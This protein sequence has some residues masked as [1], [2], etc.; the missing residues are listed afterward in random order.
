MTIN[1]H[2]QLID[3]TKPRVMGILNVTPDSFYDGGKYKSDLDFLNQTEK[4]LDD[5]ATFIDIGAYSSRPG[6]AVVE[7]EDELNRIVPIIDLIMHNFPKAK[8][9]VDTFRAIVARQCVEHGA[10]IINDISAGLMD[11]LMLTTVGE[12]HVPYIMMHMRGT[13]L[14]MNSF[15]EYTDITKDLIFYFSE[16]INAAREHGISD[17]V[18]DPGFGFSKTKEQNHDLL[19]RLGHLEILGQPVLAGISRKSMVYNELKI[20]AQ[21]A[22]NGTSVLNT[23]ALLHGANILRVHDVKEAVE[24]VKLVSAVKRG[25]KAEVAIIDDDTVRSSEY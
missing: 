1:C 4:M 21:D 2:G 9:S 10:S 16:R 20:N 3:L 5:G 6:A 19:N 11:D 24:C 22:L 23:I 14:T 8:I 12:L 17:I 15:T 13:P 7:T 25:S 18:V